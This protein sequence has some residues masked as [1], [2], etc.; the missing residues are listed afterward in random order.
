MAKTLKPRQAR[1]DKDR[2]AELVP[3]VWDLAMSLLLD[4]R[5]WTARALAK[6]AFGHNTAVTDPRAVK[7]C[8]VGAIERCAHEVAVA[9]LQDP[10]AANHLARLAHTDIRPY[11]VQAAR[12]VAPQSEATEIPQINDH[13]RNGGYLAIING[14]SMA[15]GKPIDLT[16]AQQ[17]LIAQA[18][19]RS[20]AA[21]KGWFT[22]RLKQFERL[23]R[24][25]QERVVADIQQAAEAER[26]EQAVMV[27]GGTI[28]PAPE[29]DKKEVTV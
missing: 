21:R 9:D 22:R 15:T 18:E 12:D 19:R 3:K 8:A 1:G 28:T 29:P 23:Q 17:D 5:R 27:F 16:D 6:D 24:Q 10:G 25:M 11:I 14:F 20:A 13:A 7:W 26:G 4:R 2:Y